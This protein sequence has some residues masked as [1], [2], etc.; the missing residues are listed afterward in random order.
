MTIQ[1][2]SLFI[3]TTVKTIYLFITRLLTIRI[4]IPYNLILIFDYQLFGSCNLLL[5]SLSSFCFLAQVSFIEPIVN[6][7]SGGWVV[8]WGPTNLLEL[9][10]PTVV[11]SKAILVSEC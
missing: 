11:K 5:P 2:G 1:L 10:M 9:C 3:E 7:L 8:D 6:E 4:L